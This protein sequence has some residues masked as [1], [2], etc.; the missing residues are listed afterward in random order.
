MG[1]KELHKRR[2]FFAS[3][4]GGQTYLFSDNFTGTTLNANWNIVTPNADYSIYQNG[5]LIFEDL[6]SKASAGLARI[7][8]ASYY[9]STGVDLV[10]K[11]DVSATGAN[12]LEIHLRSVDSSKITG[13]SFENGNAT[14]RRKNSTE[15]NIALGA[16]SINSS[17]KIRIS[18]GTV[19]LYKWSGSSWTLLASGALPDSQYA[20]SVYR[21]ITTIDGE[22]YSIDNLFITNYNY[23]TLNP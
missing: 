2:S 8:T 15:N 3:T 12:W 10:A 18:S 19:Y 4:G 13:I 6:V 11:F 5:K 9:D 14:F 23:A 20:F 21:A 7:Q 1:L 16:T 17:F 22:T